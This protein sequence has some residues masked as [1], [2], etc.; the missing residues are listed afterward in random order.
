MKCA[1]KQAESW[2]GQLW[3]P[4]WQCRHEN[5]T[6]KS[7]LKESLAVT[8]SHMRDFRK[9]VSSTTCRLNQTRLHFE[10]PGRLYSAQQ[11]PFRCWEQT[12][13][14]KR[15]LSLAVIKAVA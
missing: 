8:A 12:R 4:S 7:N 13:K 3:A 2:D 1:I 14:T 15:G 6:S 5:A 10:R 9:R 11:H